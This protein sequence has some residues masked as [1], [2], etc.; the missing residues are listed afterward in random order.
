VSNQ[1]QIVLHIGTMKSGTTYLQHG[2]INQLAELESAGWLYPL[3]FAPTQGAINHE[4][5]I[6][7]LVGIRFR[8]LIKKLNSVCTHNG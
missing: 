5:A 3:D 2:I 7:G 8:G 6:Y 4:R 1:P